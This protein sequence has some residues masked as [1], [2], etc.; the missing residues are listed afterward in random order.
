MIGLDLYTHHTHPLGLCADTVGIYVT[1]RGFAGG[2]LRNSECRASVWAGWAP[3]SNVLTLGPV[4]AK[5]GLVLGAIAGYRAHP[6]LPMATASAAFSIDGLTW[7]R[8]SYLP[9]SPG[10]Q[11]DGMHL[12]IERRF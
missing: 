12:S 7:V 3:E 6:V 8:F 9:R 11:S 2:A 10:A 4:R 1:H 5:A